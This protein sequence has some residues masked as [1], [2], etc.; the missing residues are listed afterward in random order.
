M[1]DELCLPP[2]KRFVITMPFMP[3]EEQHYQSL[4]EE[5]CEAVGVDRSGAPVDDDWS[6]NNSGTIQTMKT[7]LNRLRQTALHPEVGNLN[8]RHLGRKEGPMRTVDEVLEAMLELSESSIR[9]DQRALLISKL[10]QGQ[11]LEN[12]PRVKDALAVWTEVLHVSRDLVADY[13][14]RLRKELTEQSGEEDA[15]SREGSFDSEDDVKNADKA[16]SESSKIGILRG[17][18]R[19]ALEI[20]HMVSPPFYQLPTM[21]VFNLV[22]V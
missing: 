16:N 14:E 17:R 11:A 1:R 21:R 6:P 9:I 13:R 20:E 3:V 22:L 19:G 18:L 10:K 8:R 7:W 5:M 2:Q 4:F 12:G 15:K